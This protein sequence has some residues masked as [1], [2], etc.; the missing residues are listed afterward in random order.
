[1]ITWLRWIVLTWMSGALLAS[2]LIAATQCWE[3]CSAHWESPEAAEPRASVS[4]QPACCHSARC[5]S[6]EHGQVLLSLTNRLTIEYADLGWNCQQCEKCAAVRSE[7]IDREASV[8]EFQRSLT[9]N[10]AWA[11][12]LQSLPLI[13]DVERGSVCFASRGEL[14]TPPLQVMFCTW[15]K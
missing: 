13:L 12:P 2:P 4:P 8:P 6:S 10:L 9:G 3:C 1:M 5:D 11:G 14:P 15:Q 7:P